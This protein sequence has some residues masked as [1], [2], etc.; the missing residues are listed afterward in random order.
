VSG[1]DCTDAS[2][3]TR[4]APPVRT[5]TPID[6]PAPQR[7]PA[8]SVE[9]AVGLARRGGTG[10]TPQAVQRL[11]A[12]AGNAAVAALLA[13]RHGA[14][15]RP[16]APGPPSG[17]GP[18]SLAG[19]SQPSRV[20]GVSSGELAE[21]AVIPRGR[22]CNCPGD[23][24]GACTATEPD[25]ALTSLQR[26]TDAVVVV[27][28][29]CGC[30]GRCGGCGPG[31]EEEA[32]S[33]QDGPPVQRLHQVPESPAAVAGVQ[34][35]GLSDLNP[36]NLAKKL[37]EKAIGA[38]RSL[39][40]SAWSTA[41]SLGTAAWNNVKGVGSGIWNA[42]KSTAGTLLNTAKGSGTAAWNSAKGLGTSAWN[43]AKSVG[44]RVWNT[45]KSAGA[46]VWNTAQGLGS[47]AWSGAKSL[48]SK[49]W[50]GAKSLGAKAWAAVKGF[51]SAALAKAKG[52]AMAAL[53]GARSLGGRAWGLAK[54]AVGK[55]SSNLCKAVGVVV[56]KVVAGVTSAAKAAWSGAKR[57]GAKAWDGAKALGGAVASTASR[58]AG[59]AARF[60]TTAVS[61][62]YRTVKGAASNAWN[63]A[64][65]LG[66][67]A[68]TG[69]KQAAAGA[70]NT[71]KSLGTKAISTARAL[72]TKVLGKAQ[73]LGSAIANTAQAAGRKVLGLADKLTGGAASKVA[74]VANKILGKAA[75]LLS[76]VLNTAKSLASKAINTAKDLGAKAIN[77][78][79]SA[80]SKAWQA[81]KRGA[82]TALSTAKQWGSKAFNTAKSLGAKAWS[83]AKQWGSK[84]VSTAK[85][86]AGKAWNTAKSWGGKAWGVIKS[87]AGKVWNT[88]KSAGAKV[89]GFAKGVG[90]GAVKVAKAVG[91]DKAWH[92]A[93]DLGG[94]ALGAVKTA[95]GALKKR[96]K[97]LLDFAGK[98][99]LVGLAPIGIACRFIECAVAKRFCDF[100]TK[101]G[102]FLAGLKKVIADPSIITNAIRNAVALMIEK[103]PGETRAAFAHATGQSLPEPG[104][105]VQ[106]HTVQRLAVQRQTATRESASAPPQQGENVWQG[107]W[108][109]LGPKLEYLKDNWWDAL[110]QTGRQ[111]LFPW[112]GMG[113]DLNE[114]WAQIEKGGNA[115][116]S[117]H[118]S[119]LIDAVIASEKIVVGILGRWWGWFAIASVIVGAV[120]GAFFG[121][122][123]A[124]PGAAAGFEV[125]SSV[126]EGILIADAALQTATILKSFYNITV[127]HDTGDNREKDYDQIADS[128]TALGITGAMLLLGAIAVRFAKAIISRVRGLRV[129][130]PKVEAPKTGATEA[131]PSAAGAPEAVPAGAE[132]RPGV[133][134][135]ERPGGEQP[136]RPGGD[137]EQ[138]PRTEVLEGERVVAEQPTADGQRKVKVTEDACFV[139]SGCE[140][141]RSRYRREIESNPELDRELREAAGLRDPVERARRYTEIEQRLNDARRSEWS[142]QT[143]EAKVADIERI[144]TVARRTL[145]RIEL[146]LRDPAL[147]EFF[148]QSEIAAMEDE[149]GRIRGD[150]EAAESL[151]KEVGG[152][153]PAFD[154]FRA[155][156][157]DARARAERLETRINDAKADPPIQQAGEFKYQRNPKHDKPVPDFARQPA[158]PVELLKHSVLVGDGP[159]RINADP[160]NQEYVIFR[161]HQPGRDVYH[162]YALDAPADWNRLRPAERR[163]L[164]NA[165]RVDSRGR[166]Q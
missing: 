143:P 118:F 57:L 39:G 74:G 115:L 150:Q 165:G 166:I 60:A 145:E 72:G 54:R 6:D 141:I 20:A 42:A 55:L 160:V 126:G 129:E 33:P 111:L 149:V 89:W 110:K 88:T 49:I 78:A 21:G 104:A 77:A 37:A 130:P 22:G 142:Q 94:K 109:H 7:S 85:S 147:R 15:R 43:T 41:K 40:E 3:R 120:I 124:I 100:L 84:A 152:A 153:D 64:K 44:A 35:F 99:A 116:K 61:G 98:A 53:N 80:A 87:G 17:L 1:E 47:K 52:L 119:E 25:A 144:S 31:S 151:G 91:L 14:S 90:R 67:R 114:L 27:Q 133:E 96:A 58:W 5:R 4:P 18:A 158:R 162:G 23:C 106:R 16:A 103:V 139:C 83:T 50:N 148:D 108:R 71:A 113:K 26:L 101:F 73:A 155:E 11:Q 107:I 135:A 81:A 65:S 24:A 137:Q 95:A 92:V 12:S 56:G 132:A 9:Q 134:P 102:P 51:G 69:A 164:R 62:A 140:N 122:A 68:F 112:E 82:S 2:D 29:N 59:K 36:L 154:D 75:G 38:I 70:W 48:G 127:Q 79:K 97:P 76:W 138:Q 159:G 163:A 32:A 156:L 123:G 45:A 117:L 161:E 146:Q 13:R 131:A 8:L 30:G 34:R 66:T 125:A 46:S 136:D 121:G 28:G 63:T 105:A 157:D 93:K 19:G 128:G 10:L 86:W